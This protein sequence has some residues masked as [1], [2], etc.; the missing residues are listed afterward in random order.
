ML[1]E[2]ST[3]FAFMH[4]KERDFSCYGLAAAGSHFSLI[5]RDPGRSGFERNY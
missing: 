4:M 2:I 1:E 5:Y 3:I